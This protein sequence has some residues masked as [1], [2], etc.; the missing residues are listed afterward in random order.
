MF[1]LDTHNLGG[2]QSECSCQVLSLSSWRRDARL[3]GE[4]KMVF[5]LS[6]QFLK[7][8]EIELGARNDCFVLWVAFVWG[9]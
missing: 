9:D 7:K 8:K 4:G 3:S 6:F 1:V 5:S 2:V